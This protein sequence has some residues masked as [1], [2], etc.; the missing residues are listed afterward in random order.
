MVHYPIKPTKLAYLANVGG[1]SGHYG[2]WDLPGSHIY[3]VGQARANHCH[4]F[5]AVVPKFLWGTGLNHQSRDSLFE[6]ADTSLGGL[7]PLGVRFCLLQV[8]DGFSAFLSKVSKDLFPGVVYG[9]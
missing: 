6:L 9:H 3:A 4:Q 2:F 7:H 5:N 1:L 8:A